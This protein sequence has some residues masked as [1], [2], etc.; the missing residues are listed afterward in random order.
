MFER[1]PVALAAGLLAALWVAVSGQLSWV[2]WVGFL[3]CS[4]YFAQGE[5]SPR[6]V[7]STWAT[8]LSGV[9][10]AWLIL[11][12][13]EVLTMGYS[14]AI[15]TGIV[16]AFMCLQASKRLLAFIPGTFLGCCAMFALHGD[17]L[18]VLPPLLVGA[19]MGYAMSLLSGLL[20]RYMPVAVAD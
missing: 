15:L 18:V 20:A 7:M 17:F 2:T 11:H 16:T 5:L 6:G 10:W 13:A 3:G 14:A 12:G 1:L 19:L 8:T 4:A 9:F